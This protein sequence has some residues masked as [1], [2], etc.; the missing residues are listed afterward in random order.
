[1]VLVFGTSLGLNKVV[2]TLSRS[3]PDVLGLP[4]A[5]DKL[6]GEVPSLP[7]TWDV[8]EYREPVVGVPDRRRQGLPLRVS[9]L[10]WK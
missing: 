5:T 9:R 1:V 4:S 2:S 3:V 10:V 8:P 7:G 6:N